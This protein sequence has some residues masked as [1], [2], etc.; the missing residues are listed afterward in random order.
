MKKQLFEGFVLLLV[1]VPLTIFS[2]SPLPLKA[3]LPEPSQPP[4]PVW[5][6]FTI[7]AS[8]MT[9][10]GNTQ[11]GWSIPSTH[12]PL[13]G[14]YSSADPIVADWHIKW[15]VEHGIS[16]FYL[17]FGWIRPND[18]IDRAA[19]YGLMSSSYISLLNIC[20]FYFPDAVVGTNWAGGEDVLYSDFDFLAS[21]YFS[22]TRYARYNDSQ[23]VIFPNFNIYLDEWGIVKTNN[24][25]GNLKARM[26][27]DYNCNLYIIAAFWPQTDQST[28]Q[29]LKTI[30]NATTIWGC[31]TIIDYNEPITYAQYL[32]KSK[33]YFDYWGNLTTNI[34]L[35]FVPLIA[36][37]FDNTPYNPSDPW[38]VYRNITLFEE[39]CRYS[40]YYTTTPFKLDLFFTWNDFHEGTGI[41]PTKEYKFQYLDVIRKVFTNGTEPH[42]D[43]YPEISTPIVQEFQ[44]FSTSTLVILP[45]IMIF[46]L[47]IKGI[48]IKKRRREN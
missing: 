29:A 37:G 35:P 7:G 36:P 17:D 10:W 16:L 47:K 48:K 32:A 31:D 11:L 12:T 43:E 30:I 23:I 8:Y 33:T 18:Y 5:T 13:L 26:L 40:K 34:G 42:T 46:T 14:E 44:L 28:V 39:I 2:T 45:S 22:S 20:I 6:N 9:F 15:A 24:V 27:N 19:R 4:I 21:N 41:E 3:S 38:I 25:F 1:I